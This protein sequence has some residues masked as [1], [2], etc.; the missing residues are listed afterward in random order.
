M[1]VACSAC[2]RP[3]GD[4]S[5]PQ[6]PFIR[7]RVESIQFAGDAFRDAPSAVAENGSLSAATPRT[8]ERAVSSQNRRSGLS[9]RR[10]RPGAAIAL[11]DC[12]PATAPTPR[13]VATLP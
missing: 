12:S 1:G 7:T 4:A 13:R 2:A 11:I 9:G 8:A 6:R 5:L 10:D 3:Y